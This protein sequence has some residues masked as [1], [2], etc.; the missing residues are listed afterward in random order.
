MSLTFTNNPKG[1]DIPSFNLYRPLN[2]QNSVRERPFGGVG[3]FGKKYLSP[4]ICLKKISAHCV[5]NKIFQPL[6][7]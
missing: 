3:Y 2:A 5:R 1:K 4:H 6:S 7:G